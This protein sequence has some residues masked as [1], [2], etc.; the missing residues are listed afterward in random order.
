MTLTLPLFVVDV[1]KVIKVVVK[2]AVE[3]SKVVVETV[4]KASIMKA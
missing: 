4:V 3:F 2:V 1:V